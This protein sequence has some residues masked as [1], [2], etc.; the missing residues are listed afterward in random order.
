MLRLKKIIFS[1][2]HVEVLWLLLKP[3]AKLGSF[4]IV[5]R[6][7]IEEKQRREKSKADL[8]RLFHTIF[9]ERKVLH[10]PFKGILYPEFNSIGSTLYPKLIGS[11]ESELHEIIEQICATEYS[12]ILNIGCGEGYYAVG[13][14]LRIRGAR[15]FAYDTDSLARSLC[16]Q[17]ATLNNVDARVQ[18]YSLCTQGILREFTFTKKG[19]IVCDCE[20]FELELFNQSTINNLKRC[21]LLIETHDFIDISISTKLAELFTSTHIIT[22]IKSKDDIEKVKTYQFVEACGLDMD[23]KMHL[24]AERR[25][26][27]MEW[28]F[29]E[30]KLSS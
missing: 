25:P 4:L 24:F 20:G 19:L 13:L 14:G 28:L 1:L 23:V 17:M 10:G 5:C 9:P 26:S 7:Q 2:V 6:N 18:I 8:D 15:I 16:S 30:S 21:D 11:Y 27:I 29:L 3:F 22:S 12:E